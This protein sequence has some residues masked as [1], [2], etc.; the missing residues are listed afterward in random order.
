MIVRSPPPPN[1]MVEGDENAGM[2]VESG[3]GRHAVAGPSR[4]IINDGDEH[5]RPTHIYSMHTGRRSDNDDDDDDDDDLLNEEIAKLN[6]SDASVHNSRSSTKR[7]RVN[8][9]SVSVI[10]TKNRFTPLLDA[11]I[12]SR[13]VLFG[14]T[15]NDNVSTNVFTNNNNNNNS[16]YHNNNRNKIPPIIFRGP[17]Q[18]NFNFFISNINSRTKN[19]VKIKT[20]KN[21]YFL[22]TKDLNDYDNTLNT[23]K[24]MNIEH[25][26]HTPKTRKPIKLV[27]KGLPVNVDVNDI[28]SDILKKINVDVSIKQFTKKNLE[29]N[30][31]INLPIYSV[32]FPANT[33]FKDIFNIKEIFYCLVRWEK[34][35]AKNPVLQ[36]FNCLGYG[37]VAYNCFKTSK[38]LKCGGPHYFKNC[39]SDTVIKCA[40][41][42]GQHTANS[43]HCQVFTKISEIVASK[44]SLRIN[45]NN[46]VLNLSKTINPPNSSINRS[47][48]SNNSR[49]TNNA[50]NNNNNKN[51]I[52]S[53]LT[54]A[55]VASRNSNINSYDNN[56][57]NNSINSNNDLALL[58][59][60]L[61]KI[62]LNSIMSCLRNIISKLKSNRGSDIFHVITTIIE[63]VTDTFLVD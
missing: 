19:S 33:N 32:V 60:S 41:C 43:K 51:N 25:H 9:S 23:L 40:N 12:E 39:T 36:C 10:P 1:R 46:N 18:H 29:N 62:G 63:C 56:I 20:N 7:K 42:N 30:T 49:N 48:F 3:G 15:G 54:Y 5:A 6:W 28:K 24:Q 58:L 4:V 22:F 45:R 61:K 21:T 16:N 59:E 8:T 52:N 55:Q 2:N 37:H 35:N 47:T 50:N 44:R 53:S 13:K 34:F 31:V 38:C 26:T 14:A 27:L 17:L 57:N 11:T